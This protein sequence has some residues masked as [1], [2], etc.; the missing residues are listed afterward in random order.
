[1]P[2]TA[3]I[4]LLLALLMG[5]VGVSLSRWGPGRAIAVGVRDAIGVRLVEGHGGLLRTAASESGVDVHLLGGIMYAESR[6]RSGQQSTA[7]ALG[8]MQLVPAAAS[9]AAKR[10]GL[11]PPS[12]EQLLNDDALNVRLG[13]AHLAWLL[14]HRGEWDL[15]QVLVSYNAGRARLMGWIERAGGYAAWRS[16]QL[17]AEA[18]GHPHT[19]ALHYALSVFEAARTFRA[20]GQL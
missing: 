8:L 15:E 10:L 18:G 1:M 16:G 11:D 12:S 19:G 14:Q 3:R 9:D 17:A 6:G 20:R 4:L 2:R 7:G 13:A 5:V